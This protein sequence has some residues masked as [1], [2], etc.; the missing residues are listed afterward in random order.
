MRPFRDLSQ[1]YKIISII[2]W[3]FIVKMKNSEFEL[4][5]RAGRTQE[6][7]VAGVLSWF[8]GGAGAG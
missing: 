6:S 2:I 5:I 4:R 8:A 7:G 3:D 1:I